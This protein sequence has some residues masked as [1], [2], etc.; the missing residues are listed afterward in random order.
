MKLM[1]T[2][3][4]RMVRDI[5]LGSMM[6]LL[7]F[8]PG[9]S[10]AQVREQEMTKTIDIVLVHGAFADGSSWSRVIGLLQQKGYHVTAVQNALASLATDAS[11]TER[12]IA[13]QPHDVLLVGHSWGGA[14]ISVAGNHPKVKGLVYL[15][16]LAP[17]SGES[18][19]QLLQRLN[20][21]M[22]GLAPDASG[23]IWLDNPQVFGQVMAQDLAQDEIARLAA[24]QQPIAASAFS[25]KVA[26]AAWRDKPVWYLVTEGDH[27]L[28]SDVQRKLAQ[29]MGAQTRTI[30]SSHMSLV[31]HP[32]DVATLI[33]QAAQT[34][35]Q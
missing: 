1:S 4:T 25:E 30:Q 5:V 14:V 6:S 24:V 12:V 18:V 15:S 13:R 8:V 7:F 34:L 3:W 17:D 2:R 32:D 27:A 11:A 35:R 22:E 10:W 33:D 9:L 26:H 21:P 20:A 31:S 29:M 16:A 19:A 23:L 28:P